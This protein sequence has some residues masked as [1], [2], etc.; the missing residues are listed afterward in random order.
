MQ[1]KGGNCTA[2]ALIT[3]MTTTLCSSFTTWGIDHHQHQQHDLQRRFHAT[4]LMDNGRSGASR[5]CSTVSE[6]ALTSTPSG[7]ATGSERKNMFQSGV[8]NRPVVLIGCRGSGD[9]LNR[10]ANSIVSRDD[11][12]DSATGVISDGMCWKIPP[13]DGRTQSSFQW[14]TIM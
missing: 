6:P 12:S 4:T 13:R 1:L 5:L 11:D 9:E 7:G 2:V 14:S 10:L 8:Y 3:L